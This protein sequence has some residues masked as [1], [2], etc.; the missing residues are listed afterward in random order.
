LNVI[1]SGYKLK[2]SS[3]WSSY[4]LHLKDLG[5]PKVSTILIGVLATRSNLKPLNLYPKADH[6]AS[7]GSFGMI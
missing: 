2:R 5:F 1:S 7:I 6:F 4:N 3:D